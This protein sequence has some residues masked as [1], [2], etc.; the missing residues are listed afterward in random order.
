MTVS[1]NYEVNVY[2][3]GD[4]ADFNV[5]AAV[6]PVIENSKTGFAL[7]GS[8]LLNLDTYGLS[9]EEGIQAASWIRAGSGFKV[10]ANDVWHAG[11][12]G[13]G[14]GLDADTVDGVHESTFMRKSAN[15]A[16]DMNN[17]NITE[18]NHLQFNDPGPGE[19][20]E[21]VGGNGWKIYESP[22]NLTTNG[23]GNLQ[24]VTG[25]TRRMTLGSDG[26]L[27][28]GG[29]NLTVG[30]G[31][32]SSNIYM[33]DSNNTTRR[34]HCNSNRIGFLS[35]TNIWGSYAS[36]SGDWFSDQSVRSPIFYDSNDTAFYT[37]PAGTTIFHRGYTTSWGVNRSGS[38]TSGDGLSLYGNY[39]GGEP[40]Y[41]MMFA[42][43]ATF[44]GHGPMGASDWAT[45]FTMNNDTSRGWIFRRVGAGNS[46]S[47]TAGGLATFDNSIHSP[48][49]YDKDNTNFFANPSGNSRTNT[50]Q[51]N[52][53]GLGTASNTSGT[54]RLNMGGD[55]DMNNN[56]VDYV[57]QL[58][59]HDGVRFVGMDNDQYLKFK[60]NDATGGG[61]RFYDGD[62]THHGYIYGDGT[63][64]FGLLDNDG[65]WA[66]R[67][68]TGTSP[69]ELS[70]NNNTEFRVYTSYTLS[71]GS[72][73]APIFY[74]SNDT[75]YYTNPAST[76]SL[77]AVNAV[78]L[79]TT[80]DIRFKSDLEKIEGAVVK[81]KAISGYTYQLD[82]HEDRKAGL[83]AQEVEEVLP[84]AVKGSE[85]KKLL[86]YHATIA[87][88]VE[89]VKEQQEQIETLKQR[90]EKMES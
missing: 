82:G 17:N 26:G 55:I 27:V 69:L 50:E 14:S 31:P 34:I 41:G 58:H 84:E 21:W 88:L 4:I 51:T 68:Q 18:V 23:A 1:S 57:N 33:T 49:F 66:V 10:G 77:N 62:D 89:A 45:Y 38:N 65:Q 42:G 30:I 70:C 29:A 2:E 3:L 5:P 60:W 25:S 56:N 61:I 28:L 72:S 80:S 76:S 43:R 20:L 87:L 67:I 81:V 40:T 24:F 36:N 64:R 75:A 32:T 35:S 83:I 12:D 79:N 19:G 46:A 11:N 54:H 74:D 86:D 44:G 16:L 47:I 37:N 7:H 53:L 63:G 52:Y 8:E 15:S 6:T 13:S 85:H 90:I 39:G 59:F 71:L 78:T 9:A 22:D 73:R 48:I